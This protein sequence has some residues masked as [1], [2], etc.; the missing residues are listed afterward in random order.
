MRQRAALTAAE[1]ERLYQGKLQGQSVAEIA[2]A[3]GCS[4]ACVRKWWQRAKHEG[5]RGLHPRPRGPR[6][7]GVLARTN[8]CVVAAALALKHRHP[9]WGADRVLVALREDPQLAA[10]R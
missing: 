1:L 6:P 2:R 8:P 3:V 5:L 4:K 9:R 10:L 7:H